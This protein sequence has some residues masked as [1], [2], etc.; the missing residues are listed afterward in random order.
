MKF[1]IRVFVCLLC[2]IPATRAQEIKRARMPAKIGHYIRT[3]KEILISDAVILL[4]LNADA[5]STVHCLHV[6]PGCIETNSIIGP[7]PSNAAVWGLVEGY[8]VGLIAAQHLF[9]WQA[10]KVDPEARHI[11]LLFPIVVGIDEYWTVTG[12]VAGANRLENARSRVMRR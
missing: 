11:N 4:A 1:A 10:N 2:C 9:W 3:H 5:G 12:S 7:R 8:A 6:S